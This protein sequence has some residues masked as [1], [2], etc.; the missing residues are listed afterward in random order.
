MYPHR[1][2]GTPTVSQH[3]MFDSE[4]LI[5]F[6]VLLVGFELGSWDVKSDALPIEPPR[7][8]NF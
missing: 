6:F 7:H 3:N 2:L 1:G 8:P 5:K 4:K